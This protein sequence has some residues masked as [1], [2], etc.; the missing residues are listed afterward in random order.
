VAS[1]A[2][3]ILPKIV[4]SDVPDRQPMDRVVFIVS[5]TP[6]RYWRRSWCRLASGRID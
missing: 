3:Y 2:L 4:L 5:D 1:A 6:R